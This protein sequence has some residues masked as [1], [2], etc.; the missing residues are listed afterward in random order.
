M[1][2]KELSRPA[3]LDE[4]YG[5]LKENDKAVILGG[6]VFLKL[7]QR[8]IPLVIDLAQLG[9]DKIELTPDGCMIGAMVT[10]RQVEIDDRLPDALRHCVRQIG[11][12]ALRNLATLGGSVM[13]R[14]PFSDV[15]TVLLALNAN[16]HF[17]K[18]GKMPVQHFADKGLNEADI[19]VGI[20]IPHVKGSL[21]SAYKPV[22]TDF[23]LVNFAISKS[24]KYT[25][26]FGAAPG[27]AKRIEME[28]LADLELILSSFTFGD[29][30]RAS[31]DYR[32][33][34]AQ[35]MLEDACKEAKEW[36]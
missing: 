17:H 34:L 7:Q 6:G 1:K 12:I 35:S 20:S 32:R 14:Y 16:L 8:T 28:A 19:L 30:R 21:F 23:S 5:Q 4:A 24:E 26:S 25:I 15:M 3:T 13:G 33:A 11:G 29:D 27:R 2:I 36:K 9:L 22:Y 31:G 10:L 18:S